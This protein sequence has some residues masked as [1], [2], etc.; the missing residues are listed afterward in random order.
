MRMNSFE[1]KQLLAL[2]R[3]G[4]YA[5]AGEEEAI[6]LAL[7]PIAKQA[8][9]RVLDVGCGRGGTANY[10]YQ[11]GWGRVVG[12]DRELDSISRAQFIYPALEFQACDVVDAAAVLK[13][14]FDLIYLFNAFY[15]FADQDRALA[16]MR[17]LAGPSA[18]LVLFDYVD[19]GGYDR[20]RVMN[21]GEPLIP[22]PLR[23]ATF[24]DALDSAGWRL[25]AVEDMTDRYQRWY[26][27]LVQRIDNKRA[28]IRR[29]AGDEGFRTVRGQ[30]EAL[31]SAVLH[32]T[33][34]GAI[35]RAERR[36]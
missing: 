33:L 9:R 23:L 4:D 20:E 7:R 27:T 21:D 32:G 26:A 10:V 11:H 19:R 29:M 5:H 34:G 8:G 35:V 17:Q 3:E 18:R 13:D 14:H 31:L 28:Q 36:D 6:E 15:A 24:T 25:T 1:G 16:V 30:Y 22:R 2:I 12:I